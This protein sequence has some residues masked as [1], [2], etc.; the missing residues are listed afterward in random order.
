VLCAV[1]ARRRTLGCIDCY[2]GALPLKY[3]STLAKPA[4]RAD[5]RI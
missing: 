4:T 3:E 5:E 2:E 1:N